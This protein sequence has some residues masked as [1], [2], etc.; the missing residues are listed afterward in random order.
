VATTASQKF[1]AVALPAAAIWLGILTSGEEFNPKTVQRSWRAR[2]HPPAAAAVAPPV[3][4][5]EAPKPPET[6]KPAEP[7]KPKPA[8]P[9]VPEAPKPAEPAKPAPPAGPAEVDFRASGLAVASSVVPLT[10]PASQ[11]L[12]LHV[13]GSG[14]VKLGSEFTTAEKA[15]SEVRAGASEKKREGLL[16]LAPQA[17]APWDTVATLA[18][19][20]AEA[21]WTNIALAAS[22]PDKAGQGRVLRLDLPATEAPTRK[23]QDPLTVKVL[24]AGGFQVNGEACATPEMLAAKVLTLHREYEDGFEAGYSESADETP[25]TVDGTGALAGG[26]VAALDALR[27]AGVKTVRLAG[28]RKGASK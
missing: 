26:V 20:G 8:K 18:A 3:A 9:A 7:E 23:G 12:D 4:P 10:V 16:F 14:A 5:P 2:M 15:L 27:S 11:R 1:G 13:T 24:P 19:G 28:I 6:P 25:W 17:R 21:G 22:H